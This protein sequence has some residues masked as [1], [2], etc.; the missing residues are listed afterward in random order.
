MKIWLLYFLYFVLSFGKD[1]YQLDVPGV[2]SVVVE[3]NLEFISDNE[4]GN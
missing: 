1:G 4:S 2:A 3:S